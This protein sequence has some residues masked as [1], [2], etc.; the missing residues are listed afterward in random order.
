MNEDIRVREVRLIDQTGQN[1]GVV[2]TADAMARAT[3]AGL[4]LVEISPDA[5]PPVAKI[6]DYGKF[7]YQ[8]QKKAAEARKRQKI[9]EI[10][11]IKMRP[12]IDDHDYDVKMRVDQALLRR[13]RQGQGDAALPRPRAGAPGAR[14]AGAAAREGRHRAHRQ[15]RVR[16][17]HGRPPD[18]DGAGAALT[19]CRRRVEVTLPARERSTSSSQMHR[20]RSLCCRIRAAW[21]RRVRAGAARR[22]RAGFALGSRDAA[23]IAS[24][25]TRCVAW[26]SVAAEL[27]LLPWRRVNSRRASLQAI[28]ADAADAR[29]ETALV[30]LQGCSSD[31]LALTAA[32]WAAPSAR[33]GVRAD[34]RG[35]IVQAKELLAL[36][37]SHRQTAVLDAG[38][39]PMLRTATG[40]SVH[41]RWQHD[42]GKALRTG[43]LF[44]TMRRAQ[45]A[46]R[47]MPW[48]LFM[49]SKRH[50]STR[51][52]LRAP[53]AIKN[54][55]AKCP[56]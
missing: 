40:A 32:D 17:A 50:R 18:G 28:G 13:R 54:R 34:C 49:L 44:A 6:L 35:F 37:G 48:R 16:A 19:L 51:S 10:K 55:R 2:A 42:G 25:Q 56:S 26:S 7:K 47:G 21:P 39:V 31:C 53:R 45:A 46:R 5:N 38:S 12:S 30:V 27:R 15:G 1:V 4:D 14:L 20:S 23:C 8:E 36:H 24:F 3:A 43:S 9:V 52:G 22:C 33:A 11:E 29:A 41:G